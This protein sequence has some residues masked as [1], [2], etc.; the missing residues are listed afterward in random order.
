VA[1]ARYVD[2]AYGSLTVSP[3]KCARLLKALNLNHRQIVEAALIR[4]QNR[5]RK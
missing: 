4:E 1:W 2:A 5:I 3:W